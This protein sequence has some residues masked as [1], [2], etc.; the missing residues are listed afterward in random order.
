M[1]LLEDGMARPLDDR[2]GGAMLDALAG[3]HH[4]DLVAQLGGGRT[5]VGVRVIAVLA[6][7]HGRISEPQV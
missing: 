6:A 4:G 5:Q 7:Q 2:S 3:V 1:R